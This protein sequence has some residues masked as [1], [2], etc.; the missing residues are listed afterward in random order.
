M[1]CLLY[2]GLGQCLSFDQLSQAHAVQQP[3]STRQVCLPLKLQQVQLQG[4]DAMDSL[5]T[6]SCCFC[7]STIATWTCLLPRVVEAAA[8]SLSLNAAGIAHMAG[9]P[10]RLA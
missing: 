10:I 7:T 8:V 9:T 3:P 6:E 5:Q 4:F 1:Q 2:W